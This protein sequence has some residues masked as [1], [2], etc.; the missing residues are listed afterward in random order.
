MTEGAGPDRALAQAV[1]RGGRRVA[2]GS[3]IPSRELTDASAVTVTRIRGAVAPVIRR[4]PMSDVIDQGLVSLDAPLGADKADGDPRAR[5][6]RGRRRPRHRCRGALRRRVGPR[7]KTAT[8]VP[9]GIAI[10]HAK[11]DAVTRPTLAT[12]RLDPGVDFGSFDGPADLVFLIAVPTAS[13]R[14]TSR[15]SPRSRAR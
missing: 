2:P 8:G 13:T 5:R 12:A 14:S 15:C 9:G 4:K 10:P 7:E 3:A 6:A 11:S 1:A